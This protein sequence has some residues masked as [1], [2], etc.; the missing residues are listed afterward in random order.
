MKEFET[1]VNNWLRQIKGTIDENNMTIKYLQSLI[2]NFKNRIEL[3]EEENL[4][5]TAK[6]YRVY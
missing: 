6:A 5:L 2:N 3:F 1:E 4:L